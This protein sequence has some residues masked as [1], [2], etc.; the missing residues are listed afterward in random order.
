MRNYR[1]FISHSWKYNEYERIIS[2]LDKTEDF[3]YSNYSISEDKAVIGLSDNNLSDKIRSHIKLSQIVLIPAGMEVNY[4]RYIQFEL[5]IAQEMRKP[6][7]GIIPFGKKRK[8][9]IIIAAAS[10]IIYWGRKSIVEAIEE[11]AL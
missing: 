6:I 7:I 4:R 8:P 3:F 1:I 5:E 10:K 9:Q 11:Y 2:F